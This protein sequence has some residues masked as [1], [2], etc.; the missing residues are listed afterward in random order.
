MYAFFFSS[1]HRWDVLKSH[2]PAKVKRIIE[3]RWS[4]KYDAVNAIRSHFVEVFESLEKLT[5][6]EENADTRSSA[7]I[8]MHSITTFSFL[9]YLGLW[10]KILLEV[11]GVQKYLQTKGLGLDQGFSTFFIIRPLLQILIFSRPSSNNI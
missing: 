4:A 8:L 10:G 3:T 2:A 1:T 11:N 6:A 7:G 9:C 5:G